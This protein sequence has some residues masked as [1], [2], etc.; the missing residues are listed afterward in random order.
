MT[1]ICNH[2]KMLQLDNAFIS[3]PWWTNHVIA[4]YFGHLRTAEVISKYMFVIVFMVQDRF[5]VHEGKVFPD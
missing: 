4:K 1:K 2:F 3:T 5:C